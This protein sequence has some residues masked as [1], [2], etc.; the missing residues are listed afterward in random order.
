MKA[1]T[2]SIFVLLLCGCLLF[3]GCTG[4]TTPKGW[5]GPVADNGTLYV[6]SM[7]G[8]VV[9]FYDIGAD[10]KH[11]MQWSYPD[12]TTIS[13]VYGDPV[14]D[15][16]S[17]YVTCYNGKVYVINASRGYSEWKYP[18]DANTYVGAII[19]GSVVADGYL[20]FGS[21]DKYLYAVDTTT[22][23]LQWKKETGGKIWSTPVVYNGTVYMGSFDRKLYA[24][25]ALTGMKKWEFEAGGAIVSTPIVYNGTLYFGSLDRKIY[26]VNADTGK[27]LDGF[28]PFE[29]GNWFWSRAVAYNGS[30]IDCSLDGGVYAID[31]G[32]GAEMW[33]AKVNGSIRG[34]PALVNNLLVV[35]TDEGNNKGNIYCINVDTH[36]E[37]WNYL[38]GEAT[39]PAIHASIGADNNTVYV[40]T[41]DQKIYAIDAEHGTY[42]WSRSTGGSQ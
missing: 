29:A 18:A 42:L 30:I 40:H 20:Y 36:Q 41:T 32:T 2:L 38:T 12:G 26:A 21:S 22:K 34:N 19:G 3:T 9:A 7:T 28:K 15:N 5:S 17:V 25:D 8:T 10:G 24:F 33:S 23:Q 16:G 13:Y 27:L 11:Y 37:V 39:M 6:G 31:A 4:S 35:G 1:K 14:V